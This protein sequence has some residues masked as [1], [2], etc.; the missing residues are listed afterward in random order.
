MVVDG[1]TLMD[2]DPGEW[3]SNPPDV[4]ALN[5]RAGNKPEP[6]MQTIL[7]T[8]AKTGIDALSGGQTGDTDI[9]V[10]TVEDGWD[11]TVRTH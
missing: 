3:S 7:F 5:L 9:V 8:V 1:E 2:A 11:M 10:T 6:W 4:S